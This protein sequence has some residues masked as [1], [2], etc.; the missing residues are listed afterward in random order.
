VATVYLSLGANQG[1]RRQTMKHAAELLEKQAGAITA[2]SSFLETA[3]WGFKSNYPFLNAALCIETDLPP[4]QLLNL[5]LSIEKELGREKKADHTYHDR[6]IDI[7]ILM[8]DDRILTTPQL[9]LPHPLMDKRDFVLK[10]LA[11]IAPWTIHPV[12]KKTITT[13]LN[14]LKEKENGK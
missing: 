3:P 12:K 4:L 7:D 9:V 11:E 10:P 6:P 14:E 8:Y 5:A 13:L 1:N 2:F